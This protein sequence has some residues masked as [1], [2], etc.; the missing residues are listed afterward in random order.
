LDCNISPS[1][2]ELRSTDEEEAFLFKP[3]KTSSSLPTAFEF[4]PVYLGTKTQINFLGLILAVVFL[5]IISI[6]L[7]L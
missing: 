2:L 5:G 6:T 1:V 4:K 7:I 3:L